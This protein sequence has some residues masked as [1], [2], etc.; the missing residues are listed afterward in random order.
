MT[1]RSLLTPHTLASLRPAEKEYT[2]GD[3]QCPG[4]G[5][6]VQPGG[7]RSWVLS[8]RI[9]G[10]PR[11]ITLGTWP[12]M[13]PEA[14]RA[15][16]HAK[17]AALTPPAS[18]TATGAG[19]RRGSPALRSRV[20]PPTPVFAELVARFMAER[21][22]G[23]KP[24]SIVPLRAYL[25]SQLLPAF[26]KTP[27]GA[28][29]PVQVAEWFHLYSRTRPGGANQA[30]GHFGTIFN[31]GKAQGYLPEDL[32]N[33]ATPIRRNRRQARGRMLSFDQIRALAREIDRERGA[34]WLAAQ[35]LRLI[36]LTGCRR[37]EILGL[38]WSEVQKTKLALSDAKTGPRDVLLSAPARDTLD[39]LRRET[40]HQ[41]FVFPSQKSRSGRVVSIA[42]VWAR[43][44]QAAGLPE[45]IRIHDLRHTYAS[46]AILAGESLPTAGKLLGHKT[47]RTTKRYA[48]LDGSTLSKAADTL[49]KEID[50]MMRGEAETTKR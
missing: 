6:R 40:G 11:R 21:G 9:D 47:P 3:V 13:S 17:I 31:W 44:R 33:P 48:H 20:A 23:F 45:D 32:P 35:A 38:R 8:K 43:L 7:T 49:A 30:L 4:L 10:K 1:A 42:G 18:P 15:A 37:G 50:R 29:T 19:T 22:K 24:S 36:L 41:R 12:E 39:A 28:I 27:V 2:L 14:A 46:H 16:F 5:L 26:G 34:H 25:D